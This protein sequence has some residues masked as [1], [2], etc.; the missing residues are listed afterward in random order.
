MQYIVRREEYLGHTVNFKT[1]KPSFKDKR[2]YANKKENWIIFENTHE[3]IIEKE[4]R[5]I[6]NSLLNTARRPQEMEQ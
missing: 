1:I 3:A 6:A 4:T 2:R 5:E